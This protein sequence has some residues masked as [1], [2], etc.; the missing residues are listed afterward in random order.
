[1]YE[2]IVSLE[3]EIIK[4]IDRFREKHEL[5]VALVVGVLEVIKGITI[6]NGIELN[7]PVETMSACGSIVEKNLDTG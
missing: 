1:M 6:A 2:E 5:P 4:T 3:S 7:R